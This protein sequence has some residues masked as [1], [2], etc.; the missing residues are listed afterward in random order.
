MVSGRVTAFLDCLRETRLLEATQLDEAGKSPL[1]RG[2]DP[3]PLA[4][5]LVQRQWLTPFQ[6]NQVLQGR[7][8]ELVLGPY[9]LL[10]RLGEGGMG[11]VYKACH[12]TMKRTVALKII[13]K[14]RLANPQAVQRFYQEVQI[15]AKLSHP[16]IV[17]AYD[18][19]QAGDVHYFA[20]EYVEGT[21][22][23]RLVKERGPLPVADACEYIRQ[24]ALGLQHAHERGLVHRDIKPANLLLSKPAAGQPVVK[25][26]DL[27][28]ARLSGEQGSNLTRDGSVIGTPDFLAPEQARNASA[29]DIRADIYS[30]G[31]TFYF[32]LTGRPPFQA[33]SLT[34]VLLKH[35]TDEPTP[36][37]QLRPEVPSAVA[38]ILRK[39][40]AKKPEERY[41]TPGEVAQALGA[42][43]RKK[44]SRPAVSAG[45]KPPPAAATIFPWPLPP[46]WLQVGLVAGA[47]LFGLLLLLAVVRAFRGGEAESSA[48]GEPPP[49]SGGLRTPVQPATSPR[50]TDLL[51][52]IDPA[53]HAVAGARWNLENQVLVSPP[54]D[55]FARIQVPCDLPQEY[56]LTAVV[57]RVAGNMNMGIIL[58]AGGSQ[59]MVA[60]DGWPEK[61][62]KSGLA[63]LDGRMPDGQ[64]DAYTGRL[65]TINKP[66]EVVCVVRKNALRVTVDGKTVIHYEGKWSR[67]S[68][69][70]LLHVPD[71]RSLYLFS[72]LSVFRFSKL[73]LAP[74]EGR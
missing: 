34:E 28:L 18:A 16:N 6:V 19:G 25:V 57:E 44:G 67:L 52:G 45:P 36:V 43:V 30:L 54:L 74:L 53:R 35:Q 68:L 3:A 9:Q 11:Q 51:A 42:L 41:A 5:D 39:M 73:T 55:P 69:P 49:A 23:A 37:E 24:A 14:D 66:S 2:D 60:L 7:G 65:F 70:F 63:L 47:G 72:C 8:K 38:N 20:M 50:G 12:A 13:R 1:A 22:L 58:V 21:D 15:A 32:L 27:G 17:L 40:M 33:E 10:D 48:K 56:Q 62:Y 26:L 31:G 46:R 59:F 64:A 61:G 29:V 4:R 71:S